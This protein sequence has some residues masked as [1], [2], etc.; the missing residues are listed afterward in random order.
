MIE[1]RIDLDEPGADTEEARVARIAR[2]VRVVREG[3]GANCSSVGS[4][5]DTLFAAAV[6]GGAVLAAIATALAKEEVRVIAAR[7]AKG[8]SEGSNGAAGA[9]PSAGPRP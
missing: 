4:V 3:H 9:P 1:A 2:G 7:E 6:V 5:V 8:A